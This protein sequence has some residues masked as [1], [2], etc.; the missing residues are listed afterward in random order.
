[1]VKSEALDRTFTAL[2]DPTRR[3]ILKRLTR[4]PA[5]ITEL[6]RP[7]DISLP[8]VMKHIRILENARLVATHKQGR[9]R[10]CRLAPGDLDNASRWIEAY[11]AEWR[12]RLDRLDAIIERKKGVRRGS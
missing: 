9:T 2:S 10:E 5:S 3:D 1:M 6:A 11:Q 8:G 7:Y 4:G 12:T